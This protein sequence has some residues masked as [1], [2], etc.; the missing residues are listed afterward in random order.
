MFELII[1]AT[2]IIYVS[3]LFAILLNQN[4]EQYNTN[5]AL[6][7]RIDEFLHVINKKN[8][9]N[10]VIIKCFYDINV[11]QTVIEGTINLSGNKQSISVMI[12]DM[13]FYF[14]RNTMR[15]LLYK[16]YSEI[17]ASELSR[18]IGELI[19]ED[20]SRSL[21]KCFESRR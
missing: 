6:K 12:S 2:I 9:S 19:K 17:I 7:N 10:S 15:W 21:I 13:E 20:V 11:R 14:T 3:G 18:S 8:Q 5:L 1:P 4:N 16:K